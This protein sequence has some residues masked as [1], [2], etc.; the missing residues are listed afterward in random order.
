ML[1][2]LK[3]IVSRYPILLQIGNKNS[4]EPAIFYAIRNRHLNTTLYLMEMGQKINTQVVHRSVFT[5]GKPN[6]TYQFFIELNRI[7]PLFQPDGITFEEWLFLR[8]KQQAFMTDN[9]TA[10]EKL[11]ELRGITDWDKV[12]SEYRGE[13]KNT[14]SPKAKQVIRDLTLKYLLDEL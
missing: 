6:L 2:E 11:M 8:C 13:R 3:E 14:S 12:I 9:I 7:H 10:I 4:D 5:T 1:P